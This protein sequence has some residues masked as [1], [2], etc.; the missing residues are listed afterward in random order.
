MRSDRGAAAAEPLAAR[1]P[2]AWLDERLACRLSAGD[3]VA[4]QTRES[5]RVELIVREDHEVLEVLGVGAR[6]VIE[7]V[8]RVVHARGAKQ[9]ERRRRARRMRPSPIGD[10]VVH[11]CE[12]GRVE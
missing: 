8:Q 7:P 2:I 1:D 6:I 9:R 4:A 12:I 10:S 5:V 3:A 11:R